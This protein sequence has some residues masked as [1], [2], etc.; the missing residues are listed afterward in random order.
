[1]LPFHKALHLAVVQV[2]VADE[3]ALASG[4]LFFLCGFGVQGEGTGL[5]IGEH[6]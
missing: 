3:G 4:K 5:L 6:C 2:M 1:M